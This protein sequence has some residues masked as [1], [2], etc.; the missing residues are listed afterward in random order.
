M[1][2]RAIP[3]MFRRSPMARRSRNTRAQFHC[4]LALL[5]ANSPLEGFVG[6]EEDCDWAFIDQLHGHHRLEN[7]GGDVHAKLAKRFAK[8]FVQSFRQF[9]R[10]RRNEAGPPLPARI[11]VE[12]KLRNHQRAALHFQQRTVHLTLLVFEDA[13]V[14]AFSR[15]GSSHGGRI[16]AAD[17]EKNH[18][19][20]AH[21]AGHASFN[22]HSGPANPLQNRSHS[23]CPFSSL[24][25]SALSASLRYLFLA[26]S[27]FSA[28]RQRQRYEPARRTLAPWTKIAAAP[29]NNRAP[30]RRFAPIA[31]FSLASVGPVVPL[32][33]SRL[34][35]GV[36]KIRNRR[37]SKR[38]CSPQNILQHAAQ[39]L[40][41]FPAEFRSQLPRM[42]FGSPQAL[43]RVDIADA[44]QHALV[45][46][47]RLDPRAPPANPVCKFFLAHFQ[48][49][50][51]ESA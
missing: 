26:F 24:R 18:Q 11:A 30:N 21:F 45:Q 29:R 1:P 25:S 4:S 31:V 28:P 14:R 50:S 42:D 41:L 32:I 10:R 7:A 35:V 6:I 36:K 15:H 23:N 39:R 37:S 40:R 46:Q 8:F 9:R 5:Q 17:T 27:C 47:Q 34:A 13:Q 38:D 51:A 2:N 33:F 19:P 12:R 43:I 48:R 49:V 3:S 22:R 44:A 20:D 16:F